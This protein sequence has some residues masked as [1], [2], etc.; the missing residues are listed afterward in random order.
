MGFAD[1]RWWCGGGAHST[2]K[3]VSSSCLQPLRALANTATAAASGRKYDTSTSRH[4]TLRRPP[5]LSM[6]I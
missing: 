6:A 5:E 3:A 2:W 1:H 4:N